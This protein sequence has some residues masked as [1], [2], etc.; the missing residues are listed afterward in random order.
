MKST[1]LKIPEKM[2]IQT[3][4]SLILNKVLS[5]KRMMKKRITEVNRARHKTI[6]IFSV[7][8]SRLRTKMPAHPQRAAARSTYI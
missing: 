4:F 3:S 5:L 8:F 2:K 1:M 6:S 7:L